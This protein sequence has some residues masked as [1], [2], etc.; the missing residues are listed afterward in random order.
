MASNHGL[1]TDS[2]IQENGY[3]IVEE[4]KRETAK[5]GRKPK[6]KPEEMMS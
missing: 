4:S 5:M 6:K 2:T 3:T 1:T